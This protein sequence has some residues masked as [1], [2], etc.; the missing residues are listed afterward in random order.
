[1]NRF[2][3]SVVLV[4]GSN[5][6]F[7][8]ANCKSEIQKISELFGAKQAVQVALRDNNKKFSVS[9]TSKAGRGS[10]NVDGTKGSHISIEHVYDNKN[11]DFLIFLN[12]TQHCSIDRI[13]FFDPKEKSSDQVAISGKQCFSFARESSDADGQYGNTSE[14]NDAMIKYITNSYLKETRKTSLT[15][16]EAKLLQRVRDNCRNASIVAELSRDSGSGLNSKQETFFEDKAS[17]VAR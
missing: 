11:K 8:D 6:S 9:T 1:M 16:V 3:L 10:L 2:I 17:G 13:V 12:T 7:A 5:N 4:F 15:K 14:R